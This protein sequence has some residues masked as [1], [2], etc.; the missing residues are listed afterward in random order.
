MWGG[1]HR[2]HGEQ[3]DG[4]VIG[5]AIARAQSTPAAALRDATNTCSADN[6][7]RYSG[8]ALPWRISLP[9]VSPVHSPS[10]NVVTPLTMIRS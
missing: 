3:A 10:M 6:R 8:Y 7:Y 2:Q 5:R 4:N 9:G 1:K